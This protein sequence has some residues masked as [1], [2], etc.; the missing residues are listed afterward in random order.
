MASVGKSIAQLTST[1][2]TVASPANLQELTV[3]Q[4]SLL[5]LQQQ[6]LRQFRLLTT[7][8]QQEG[9]EVKDLAEKLGIHN[10]FLSQL[11]EKQEEN[12]DK[13]DEGAVEDVGSPPSQALRRPGLEIFPHSASQIPPS[14]FQKAFEA[15]S[16]AVLEPVVAKSE[17]NDSLSSVII[18]LSLI[19]I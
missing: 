19:H 6:Q 5:S 12:D 17:A 1:I 9:G 4:A 13:E 18:T 15:S 3:L 11:L 2:A 8:Q 14:P 10:P 16:K 7:V